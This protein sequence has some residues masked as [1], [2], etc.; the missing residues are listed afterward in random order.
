MGINE[1]KEREKEAMRHRILQ[2]AAR[3]FID[4]G[5]DKTSIRNIADSIEYSPATIY[6]YYKDKN[7][8]LYALSVEGFTRFFKSFQTVGKYSDP[9][10]RLQ[11]L[12]R[13]YFQFAFDHPEYYDLMFIMRGP[14]ESHHNDAGWEL[15]VKSH[16]ILTE[17]VQ[18]CIDYGY[19][20]GKDPQTLSFMIWSFVHGV[21][22]LKIRNRLKMYDQVDQDK[23]V[24]DA[25]VLFNQFLENSNK[26]NTVQS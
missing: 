17:I 5:F 11:E 1:R 24:F 22:S 13:V 3:L 21:M 4:N 26:L 16:N 9:M 19:F 6:L 23:L 18:E 25:L 8:I 15:G 20:K 12:G 10:K 7:E 14:M 2:A